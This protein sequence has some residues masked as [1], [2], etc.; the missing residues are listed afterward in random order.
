M[1]MASTFL[2]INLLVDK[3]F[4][5]RF[6]RRECFAM[7]STERMN[8]A[9]VGAWRKRRKTGDFMLTHT[10]FLL[11][12]TALAPVTLLNAGGQETLAQAPAGA[13]EQSSH[14]PAPGAA[15]AGDTSQDIV[16]TA[17][18]VVSTV[19]STPISISA[20]AGEDLQLRG[21]TSVAALTGEVPSLS[22]KSGGPGQTQYAIRGLASPGGVSPTVGFYFDEFPITP[23]AGATAGKTSIDP[24][25]YDLARVEVLRGPQGTLYGASSM[26]GTIRLIPAPADPTAFSG[27][28]QAIGTD[29]KGGAMSG[30]VNAMVNVPIV[31]DKVALRIVGTRDRQG[32]FIDRVVLENFP[33]PD[34]SATGGNLFSAPRGDVLGATETRR[35]KN[36]NR[37]DTTAIRASLLIKPAESLEITPSFYYQKI[38]QNGPNSTDLYP[39]R[40][41]HYQP[42]DVAESYADRFYIASL[43]VDWDIG[44][45][46]VTSASAYTNRKTA[47]R[48]DSS[49]LTFKAF[50]DVF[51]FTG[52]SV[53]S[54]GL[55]A[56][57][58]IESN[59]TSQFT[60]ELR[61]SSNGVSPF[62]WL[63]GGFYNHYKSDYRAVTDFPASV[64][65]IGDTLYEAT[66]TGTLDQYAIFA[67]ASYDL[68]PKLRATA[69]GR[70]FKTKNNTTSQS[71]GLFGTGP[72]PT[73]NAD[74]SG[75]NPMFNLSY[76]PWERHLLYSTVSKG[77]RDGAA[78]TPVP[79]TCASDLAAIGYN[80]TPTKYDPDTVWNYEIGSKNRFFGNRLTLN[81]AVYHLKWSKVQQLIVLPTCGFAFTGNQA[82][83]AVNGGEIEV[84]ARLFAG[85][86]WQGSISYTHARYSNDSAAGVKRGDRLLNVPDWTGSASL[87]YEAPT[88]EGNSIF[89]RGDFVYVGPLDAQFDTRKRVSGYGMLNTRIGFKRD[90]L[91]VALFANNLTDRRAILDYRLS[92]TISVFNLDRVSITRP[93]TIGVDVSVGF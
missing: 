43:K 56:G 58:L 23:P 89:A 3:N 64:T 74:A 21:I 12:S 73:V 19:Q 83:A 45:L 22:S 4:G 37:A 1:T 33:L 82:D 87:I 59:P 77:F 69:G 78:I 84:E 8:S 26:G 90:K 29:T 10:V 47:N 6:S 14:V 81:A 71:A 31:D 25:L 42:L 91:S 50:G 53:D 62:S 61:I 92:Q 30:T 65:V 75:F 32:G 88:G 67:N 18:K 68:T 24:N 16:V 27:S 7:P 44:A 86:T 80:E 48:E 20:R 49:E 51:G 41:A 15:S 11:T 2:L 70:Y 34:T 85:L 38:K 28:I 57:A 40:Q 72:T 17:Q 55:G 66:I 79:S 5:L 93:R 54:G 39:F 46:N 35:Y 52:Y 60:Q 36:V 76:T 13:R 9:A 63:I